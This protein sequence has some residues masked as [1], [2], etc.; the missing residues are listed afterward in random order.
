MIEIFLP[1]GVLAVS[2][3]IIFFQVYLE[4][5]LEE[6]VNSNLYFSLGLALLKHSTDASATS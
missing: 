5:V 2:N 3:S 1:F 6:V 4:L